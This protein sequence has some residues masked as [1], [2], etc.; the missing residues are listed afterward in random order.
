MPCY[1][2]IPAFMP[3]DGGQV[4]FVEKKDHREI[5]IPCGG[6]IGC[7]LEK[8]DAW[9][10]R[11]LAE[12]SLHRHNWFV[13]LTY[14][15]EFLPVDESLNHRDWQLFAKRLRARI[16]PFRFFMCGEYGDNTQRAHYHALLFGADIP[17][18]NKCN[19][20]YSSNDLFQSKLLTECWG[21]GFT[22]LGLVSMAS[23]R[24]VASYALKRVSEELHPERYSWVTRYGESVVRTQPYGRMSLKPGIGA[25][26]LLK[27]QKDVVNHAAVF[28]NQY[29]KKVPSYFSTLL[30]SINPEGHEQMTALVQERFADRDSSNYTRDRLAVREAC[31]K[32]RLSFKKERSNHAL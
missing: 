26:W 7:R 31:A 23:A 18:F 3:L 29:R 14:A 15:D 21:N 8:I 20:V 24:Y 13:T 9:G 27:Y 1:K 5:Q 22:T 32:A 4:I 19:S 10:F 2:P 16:G 6:C 28:D 17:D 11:C 25:D 30:E 12:A